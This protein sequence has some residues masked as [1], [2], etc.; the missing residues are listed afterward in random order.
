[1]DNEN[2]I[3]VNKI[4]RSSYADSSSESAF[5]GSWGS[6]SSSSFL[7]ASF[8]ENDS[9]DDGG[10]DDDEFIA[11]L[12]RQMTDYMLDDNV[13]VKSN[14]N[15]NGGYGYPKHLNSNLQKPNFQ[16]QSRRSYADTVKKSIT[17]SQP[18]N[19]FSREKPLQQPQ[20]QMYQVENQPRVSG[21]SV[22]SGTSRLRGKMNESLSQHQIMKG[23]NNNNR[24]VRGGGVYGSGPVVGSGMR[25]IFLNGSG[26]RNVTSGTGVFLP[27]SP[28]DATDHSRKKLGCSTVLV[29]T[30][31]LQA[32]EQHFNNR[33][34]LSPSNSLAQTHHNRQVKN[35]KSQTQESVSVDHQE[36]KLPQEWIY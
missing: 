7:N 27:R 19:N 25:A 22:T 35:D 1:M 21:T 33:E 12:T 8:S 4:H 36:S 13:D 9:T 10:D 29:P 14:G 3:P 23:S 16:E 17:E 32:L 6:S 20:I 11:Q 5:I 18:E 26:T 15:G 2:L 31:V 28:T 34:S 30:R 24:G